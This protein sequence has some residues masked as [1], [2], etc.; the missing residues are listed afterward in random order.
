MR[1]LMRT[2]LRVCALA[3]FAPYERVEGFQPFAR[4]YRVRIG[5]HDPPECGIDI[6]EVCHFQPREW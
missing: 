5:R 6:G 1:T 4:F 2:T 3:A